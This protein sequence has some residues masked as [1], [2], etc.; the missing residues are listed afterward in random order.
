MTKLKNTRT[1]KLLS[2]IED[3]HYESRDGL[4]DLIGADSF[5]TIQHLRKLG[6]I[7]SRPVA[8]RITKEGAAHLARVPSNPDEAKAAKQVEERKANN[9][10]VS[11]A[12]RMQPNSV[13]ALGSM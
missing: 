9:A 13:F 10:A 6:Y 8:Y 4:T 11:R 3:G 12:I 5:M 2:A 7:E 1:K